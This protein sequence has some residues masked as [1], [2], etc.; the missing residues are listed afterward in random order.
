MYV[1]AMDGRLPTDNDFDW[2]SNNVGPDDV[3][4]T[5]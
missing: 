2:M 4:I 3:Y 5:Y 1:T